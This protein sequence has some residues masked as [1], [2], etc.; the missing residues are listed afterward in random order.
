MSSDLGGELA[1]TCPLPLRDYERITMAHAGGQLGAD[2]VRHLFLP[3]FGGAA[4][5]GPLADAAV[6]ARP[7]GEIAFTT[8][9]HVV[10][11]LSFPGGDIG[12]LAVNGTVNDL[13]MVGA[14][15][16]ALSCAFVLEEGLEL[17]TL[18]RIAQSM[19]RAAC[20]ADVRLVAGDTK[21]VESGHGDGVYITTAGVGVIPPGV[22]ISP[23]R[24]AVGDKVLVSG[25]LGRHGI[26][27]LSQ[28]DGLEFG[29]TITSDCAPL[30][31]LV[32]AILETGADVHVLRDL[33]RGGL[34]AALNEL[35]HDANVG[36][37]IDEVAVPV[38]EPVRA[39]CAFLG[40]D[41]FAVANEGTCVAFVPDEQADQVLRAMRSQ[42]EGA[43]SAIIGEVVADHRK[44]VAAR[45]AFGATRLLPL[46]LGEQ[47]PRIC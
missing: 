46:P 35:A 21:V 22:N 16:V 17:A 15:P 11:P 28:R 14:R 47:L 24:A 38:P 8:D 1:W 13:A 19:G 7:A 33:T 34:V 44:V 25:P 6:L 27:V 3:A 2:L 29:T 20:T 23:D 43:E 12:S 31:R 41:P 9:A 10:R 18:H 30:A 37:V 42:P 4:S 39:A 32:S 36:V 26:A 5:T 45:T 40:L